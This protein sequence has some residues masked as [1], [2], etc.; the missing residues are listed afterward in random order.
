MARR[1]HHLP[2]PT[3]LGLNL[4]PMVDVVMCLIIFFMLASK[5][6]ERENSPVD[7]PRAS[8]ARE[9]DNRQLGRRVV[10]NVQCDDARG[11]DAVIYRIGEREM[12]LADVERR[13]AQERQRFPQVKCVVRADRDLPFHRVEAVLLGCARAGIANVVFAAAREGDER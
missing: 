2:P 12:P 3:P 5:L 7:L 13:L 8:A 10:V 1:L 9:I 4:A 11:R 6:V